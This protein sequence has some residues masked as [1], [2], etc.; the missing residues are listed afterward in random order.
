MSKDYSAP[1]FFTFMDYQKD[2][3]LLKSNTAQA[4]KAAGKKM[5]EIA[6]ESERQ[7]L[8]TID[9]DEL[10]ARFANKAG[11]DYHPDSLQV[12]KSRFKTARDD[13]IKYVD[14]PAAFRPSV[15]QRDPGTRSGGQTRRQPA[16][17]AS[18]QT[19]PRCPS[20]GNIVFPVPLRPDLIVELHNIP[21]DLTEPEAERIAAVIKALSH[22]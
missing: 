2:K 8:R 20:T 7:D 15:A 5:L 13:F 16:A 11:T 14:N 6:D 10:H 9:V 12:Y 4:R 17:P 21:S 3:G 19:A 18:A 1:A 22:K